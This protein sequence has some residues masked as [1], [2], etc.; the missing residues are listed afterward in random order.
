M[1]SLPLNS[2]VPLEVPQKLGGVGE[3]VMARSMQVLEFQIQV[4]MCCRKD[5]WF[6]P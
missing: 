6:P 5:V 2:M 1:H 3:A 4:L